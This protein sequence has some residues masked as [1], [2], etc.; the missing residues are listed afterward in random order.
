MKAS[1][2]KNEDF[3]SNLSLKID[4]KVLQKSAPE[5]EKLVEE[6]VNEAFKE[7]KNFSFF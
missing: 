5:V 6:A 1:L 3:S 4:P 2:S 7:V